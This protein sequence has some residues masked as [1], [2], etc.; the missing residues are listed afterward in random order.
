MSRFFSSSGKANKNENMN[1]MFKGFPFFRD[2]AEIHSFEKSSRFQCAEQNILGKKQQLP[3]VELN[4]CWSF[5]QTRP[6]ADQNI[7]TV[8]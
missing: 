2:S 6:A 1:I 7:L 4:S 8:T 3:I 5:K